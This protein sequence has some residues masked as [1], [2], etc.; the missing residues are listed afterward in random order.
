[1]KAEVLQEASHRTHVVGTRRP[2]HDHNDALRGRVVLNLMP[3]GE[4]TCLA[5]AC[6][7]LISYHCGLPPMNACS[8]QKQV[9]ILSR[10]ALRMSEPCGPADVPSRSPPQARSERLCV[11]AA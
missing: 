2:D 3:S 1:M 4:A 8:G 5:V 7:L 10:P 11:E 6:R 9:A